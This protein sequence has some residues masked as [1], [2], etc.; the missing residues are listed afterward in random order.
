[1][2]AKPDPSG[3]AIAAPDEPDR[4]DHT[5][6]HHT[7][8]VPVA[9]RLRLENDTDAQ[10]VVRRPRPPEFQRIR[11]VFGASSTTPTP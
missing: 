1:M 4:A 6:E 3:L 10:V 9:P 8:P 5:S 2:T 11:K 7:E